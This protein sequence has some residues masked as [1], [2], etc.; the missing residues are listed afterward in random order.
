M[1][2]SIFH[3][4]KQVLAI[5]LFILFN[6]A[7]LATVLIV[8]VLCIL[9]CHLI[10]GRIVS[11]SACSDTAS[12]AKA[13]AKA[14]LQRREWQWNVASMSA[15]RVVIPYHG[16]RFSGSVKLDHP[17]SYPWNSTIPHNEDNEEICFFKIS[18]VIIWH[19]QKFH[20][21]IIKSANHTKSLKIQPT[22]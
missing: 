15:S 1:F 7:Q 3:F 12:A 17:K 16:Q 5:T 10:Q 4:H 19:Q 13:T 8:C 14:S 18:G 22:F 21:C 20:S 11:I 2:K 9:W 6:L